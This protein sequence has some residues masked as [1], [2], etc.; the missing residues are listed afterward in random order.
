MKWVPISD[1]SPPPID[2]PVLV[3]GTD[4]MGYETYDVLRWHKP[5]QDGYPGYESM[6]CDC[7][8]DTHAHD[9]EIT[10]THWC[11]IK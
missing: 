3:K 4:S 5:S 2:W 7:A 1:S 6:T 10:P 9:I 8:N 11:E